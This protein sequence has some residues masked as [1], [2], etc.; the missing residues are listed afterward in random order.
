MADR[1][2]T[3]DA[4]LREKLVGKAEYEGLAAVVGAIAEGAMIVEEGTRQAALAGFLGYSDVV[5]VHCE[6]V[7]GLDTLWTE[8]FVAVLRLST[9]WYSAI[10]VLTKE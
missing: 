1:P 3:L 8:T 7:A 5:N 10:P 6:I 4:F 2:P 9:Y